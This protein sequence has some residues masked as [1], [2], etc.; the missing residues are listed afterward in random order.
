MIREA[1]SGKVATVAE[2]V[3]GQTEVAEGVPE[4]LYNSCSNCL[5]VI[6]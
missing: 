5:G 1:G 4:Y 6:L 2:G 3:T